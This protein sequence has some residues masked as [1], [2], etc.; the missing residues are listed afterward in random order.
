MLNKV[1]DFNI[2][3][4]SP[5]LLGTIVFAVGLLFAYALFPM[6]SGAAQGFFLSARDDGS[7]IANGNRFDRITPVDSENDLDPNNYDWSLG[8]NS[9]AALTA[10][11]VGS[12]VYTVIQLSGSGN[13]KKCALEI[14]S[15]PTP[16]AG[17]DK[18]L[19]ATGQELSISWSTTAEI[20]GS[21]IEWKKPAAMFNDNRTLVNI[22]IGA[23][24]LII[25]IGPIVVLGSIGEQMLSRFAGGMSG[26][27]R[28]LLATLG[29]SIIFVLMGSFTDFISIA[30]EAVSVDRYTMYSTT[31]AGL[32]IT[33]KQWW[34][35]IFAA[36][37][38]GVGG[39]F[40]WGGVQKMRSGS[41]G[42]RGIRDSQ[43]A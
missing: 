6:F 29:A 20:T 18:V 43:M 36:G 35:V 40:A 33:V 39:Y 1:L 17:N 2:A 31:L 41:R 7:C 9:T 38:V 8:P 13:E 42:G 4:F 21:S 28:Y 24:I 10:A 14:S 15:T 3:G 5:R 37:F 19:T 16:V 32:A 12:G 30:Y 22:I 25:G 34:G 23:T 27:A 11:G 26:P